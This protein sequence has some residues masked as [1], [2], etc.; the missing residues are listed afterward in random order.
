MLE[1]LLSSATREKVLLYLYA[2]SEGY[3]REIAGFFS[4]DLSPVQNQLKRLEAGG[5]LA[6]RLVGRTRLYSFNP[7]YAFKRELMKLL[8]KALSFYPPE[9]R[10]ALLLNRRRPRRNGKPL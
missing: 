1:P 7:R 5:V 3:P 4:A 6:S 2:R 8:E 9:D 10:E